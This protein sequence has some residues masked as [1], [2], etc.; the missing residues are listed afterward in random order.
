MD[1][2][3]TSNRQPV[4]LGQLLVKHRV[5]LKAWALEPDSLRFQSD[6]ANPYLWS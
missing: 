2:V 6:S 4:A 3:W 1:Q 5:A